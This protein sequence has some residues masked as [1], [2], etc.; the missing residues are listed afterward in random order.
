MSTIQPVETPKAIQLH[1]N[2]K[3]VSALEGHSAYGAQVLDRFAPNLAISSM[4]LLLLCNL[5]LYPEGG[6]THESNS[7]SGQPR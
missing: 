6:S 5:I 1:R 3:G 7:A 2:N 4:V